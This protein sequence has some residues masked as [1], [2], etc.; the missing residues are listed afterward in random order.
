MAMRRD[1][2]AAEGI[3]LSAGFHG[4]DRPCVAGVATSTNPPQ[5]YSNR[6]E[7]HILGYNMTAAI[8]RKQGKSLRNFR[9][10]YY[11]APQVG[12][13]FGLQMHPEGFIRTT[14]VTKII[15]DRH[16]VT[17]YTKNSC[18]VLEIARS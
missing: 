16:C 13:R 17:F 5:S 8:L 4:P 10:V 1:A 3:K 15:Q 14:E 2:D 18:Y 11:E 12:R 6:N 9:G 7:N